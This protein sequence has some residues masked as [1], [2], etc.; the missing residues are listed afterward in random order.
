MGVFEPVEFRLTDKLSGIPAARTMVWEMTAGRQ[1]GHGVAGVLDVQVRPDVRRQGLARFLLNQ[2]LRYIQEQYFRG[3]EVHVPELNQAALGLF[4]SLGFAQVDIGRS[5]R[6]SLDGSPFPPP[7][8]TIR[9]C[10]FCTGR[11]QSATSL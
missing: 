7:P 8:S 5:Y 2:M 10:G 4:K 11:G 9:G 3:A 1:P 6:R